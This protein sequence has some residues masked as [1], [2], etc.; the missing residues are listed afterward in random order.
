MGPAADFDGVPRPLDSLGIG[1][2][3]GKVEPDMG[4]FELILDSQCGDA[5]K[6]PDEACDDGNDDD[7]DACSNACKEQT[8]GDPSDP[9]DPSD[10]NGSGSSAGPGGNNA[11]GCSTGGAP[12]SRGLAVLGM[13]LFVLSVRRR[14]D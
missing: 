3:I 9:S 2:G 14:R 1:I 11:G 4:A 12:G 8:P 6:A 10:P 7:N 13:A 5:I